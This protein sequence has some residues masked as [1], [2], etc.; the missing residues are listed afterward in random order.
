MKTKFHTLSAILIS[1]S[2]LFVAPL[3]LTGCHSNSSTT[4]ANE[5]LVLEVTASSANINQGEIV[6]FMVHDKGTLGK[7]IDV[8]WK[9]NGGDINTEKEERIARVKFDKPGTYSVS[10][11]F[12]VDGNAYKTVTKVVTVNRL[13]S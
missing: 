5:G 8:K 2:L 13:P 12:W 4:M 1:S 3:A 9:S 10:A 6:T 11:E 7:D